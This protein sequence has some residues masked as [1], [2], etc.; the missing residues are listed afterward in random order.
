M[1]GPWNLRRSLIDPVLLRVWAR[2]QRLHDEHA[3]QRRAAVHATI[4]SCDETAVFYP[5]AQVRNEAG[6]ENLRIGAY[7][8]VAGELS[9]V[10]PGGRLQLGHHC[11]VGAD[12]RIWAAASVVIGDFVLIAH[13]VDIHDSDGHATDAVVRRRDPVDLFE[14]RRERN[15][16]TVPAKPVRIG[17]DVWI[18]FKSSILKGVTIGDGAV[19]AAASVVTRDVPPHTMVAGNPARVVR[20][21]RAS[22]G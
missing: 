16:A 1:S 17:N 11:F 15:W 22:G 5:N 21:L 6:R 8:H 18:G 4:A 19:V 14:Q 2:M 9:I 7:T 10:T 12:T 3:A 13:L 20:D